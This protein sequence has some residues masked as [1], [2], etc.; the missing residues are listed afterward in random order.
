MSFEMIKR[1]EL[2]VWLYTLKHLKNIRKH[3][4]IHYT[5]QRMKY[6]VMYVDAEHKDQIIKELQ[7]YHFVRKVE[8]SYRDDIDMTFKDAIPN[9]KDPDRKSES[10]LNQPPET[11]V[12]MQD[13]VS[14]LEENKLP[15]QV[16]IESN[17]EIESK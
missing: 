8:E 12:F 10:Q 14:S 5:S 15:D 11:S 9:R 17:S 3:G 2:I 4:H 1:Q 7:R 16:D 13:L 6:A